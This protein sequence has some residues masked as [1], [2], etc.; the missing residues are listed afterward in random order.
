[1]VRLYGE[2]TAD[3]AV[4]EARV[5]YHALIPQLPYVGGRKNMLSATL[6]ST[7]VALALF[8]TLTVRGLAPEEV[9]EIVYRAFELQLASYPMP[10]LR[11]SG[12]LSFTGPFASRLKKQAIESQKRVYP[13]DWVFEFVE[14]D[15]IEFDYGL[16]FYEC[17][18]CK[19]FEP[20]DAGE[21]V[22]YLC[23]VDFPDSRVRGT[24]L[25]RTST[26]AEGAE[27]C[28]FRFKKGRQV[29][30]GWPPAFLKDR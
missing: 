9:G 15:G 19:F 24:G 13:G 3:A 18:V 14:G 20:R 26:L 10:L 5:A 11:L 4:S 21:L 6:P 29:Q 8:R 12:W 27:K 2:E 25:V 7:A 30:E 16:D 28:D 1:M 22:P 23:A 17:A